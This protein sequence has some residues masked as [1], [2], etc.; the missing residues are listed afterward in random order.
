MLVFSVAPA[1]IKTPA[2]VRYLIRWLGKPAMFLR[3]SGVSDFQCHQ[4]KSSK[5]GEYT[6]RTA[7]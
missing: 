7:Q 4:A 3:S 5:F 1:P 2:G 6:L